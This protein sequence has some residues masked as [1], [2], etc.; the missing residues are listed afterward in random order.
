[1]SLKKFEIKN[2]INNKLY[3]LKLK[4]N[5]HSL[6]LK[7]YFILRLIK[8]HK[9]STDNKFLTNSNHK[10]TSQISSHFNLIAHTWNTSQLH[11]ARNSVS[12]NNPEDLRQNRR[13][14]VKNQISG[15]QGRKFYLSHLYARLISQKIE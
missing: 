4:R 11:S 3:K 7:F 14:L 12:F 5:F 13:M 10:K 6:I 2:K 9:S 8:F 1:M 15:H